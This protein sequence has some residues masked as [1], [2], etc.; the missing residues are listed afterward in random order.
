MDMTHDVLRDICKQHKLYRTPALNDKLYCH[1]KGFTRI[2]AL[3]EYVGL[4]AL[5]LDN[6]AID[7]LE[8]LPRLEQLKCL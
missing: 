7:S 1:F 6:N 2:A 4:K 8:G 5:F 3:E